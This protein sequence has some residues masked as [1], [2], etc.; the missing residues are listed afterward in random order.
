[1]VVKIVVPTAGSFE[2]MVE[3]KFIKCGPTLP[4]P[5]RRVQKRPFS[6][7]KEFIERVISRVLNLVVLKIIVYKQLP[8]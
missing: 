4:S 1:M 6:A 3:G 7:K 2:F 5:K 8:R